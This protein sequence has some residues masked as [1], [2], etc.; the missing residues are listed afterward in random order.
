MTFEQYRL[1]KRFQSLPLHAQGDPDAAS[2]TGVL[3]P[4]LASVRECADVNDAA[5]CLADPQLFPR[6]A[7]RR[8]AGDTAGAVI[9]VYF[10]RR[11]SR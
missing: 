10:G 3:A 6:G 5:R 4:T 1:L 11:R 7:I 2:V 9:H 8:T